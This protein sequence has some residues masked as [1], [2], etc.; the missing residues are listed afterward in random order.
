MG[1]N[2][3]DYEY[4]ARKIHQSLGGTT[5][6]FRGYTIGELMLFLAVA[7]VTVVAATFV[8]AA[9]TIPILGLGLMLV[10]LLFLLHKV[11]P[12]YLWLTEWLA[13]RLSWAIKNKEY[14]NGGEDNSEVRYLTRL[15]RVYPHAIERTD[16]AL[17]GAMKVEPANMALEDD[18]AWAKAVQSLSEF[19]NSTVDFPVKIYVTLAARSMTTRPSVHIRIDSL[20]PTFVHVPC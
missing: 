6:F 18:D 19:A 9:L 17:V 2:T 5:A 11:K 20:T 14:T 4:N 12:R 15:Q 10:T 8:P 1:T 3:E 16:G 7:F 13:A